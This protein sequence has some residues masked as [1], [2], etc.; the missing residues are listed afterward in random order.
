MTRTLSLF[1]SGFVALVTSGACVLAFS[2]LAYAQ[3]S[4]GGHS[5]GGGR[6]SSGGSHASGGGHAGSGR[7]SSGGSGQAVHRGSSST[8]SERGDASSGAANRD[9]SGQTSG[10]T[11]GTATRPRDG[12]TAVGHAVER[13]PYS[14]GRGGTS[15]IGGGYGGYYPWGYGGLG[16]GGYYGYY[17]PW[18]DGPY[19]PGYP[20]I[21][22][23]GDEGAIRLKVKPREASVYVDGYYAGEVNDF[24]GVFQRLKIQPGPHRIE[25]RLDGYEALTFEVRIEPD[26]T[27]TYSGELKKLP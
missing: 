1:R 27:I 5:S 19:D 15:V 10:T 12:R 6:A 18:W 21:Y 25:I 11:E 24:D 8:T 23:F 22:G 17:D 20:G 26:R 4:R 2:S 3:H 9:G 16:F 7:S 13:P 14:S